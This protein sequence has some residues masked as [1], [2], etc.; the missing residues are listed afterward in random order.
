MGWFPTIPTVVGL[1]V[2]QRWQRGRHQVSVPVHDDE[3]RQSAF[4]RV[5]EVHNPMTWRF[6]SSYN[7]PARRRPSAWLSRSAFIGVDKMTPSAA[8]AAAAPAVVAAAIQPLPSPP[9]RRLRS[10]N[11]LSSPWNISV[12]ISVLAL[13]WRLGKWSEI[14]FQRP[15]GS[16]AT[17]FPRRCHLLECVELRLAAR[18]IQQ[19]SLDLF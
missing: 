5:A 10:P 18:T 9:W 8:A 2:L 16:G 17:Q 7:R 1:I 3:L 13:L 12:G 14:L 4:S 15:T 6:E 11:L 19:V